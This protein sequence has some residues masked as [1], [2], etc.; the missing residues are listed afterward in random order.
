MNSKSNPPENPSRAKVQLNARI[1]LDL[2]EDMRNYQAE[3]GMKRQELIT[4]ALREYLNRHGSK[5]S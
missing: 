5:K 3:T 4:K 2:D 1:D